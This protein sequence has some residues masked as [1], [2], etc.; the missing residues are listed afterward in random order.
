MH[1]DL[2]VINEAGDSEADFDAFSAVDLQTVPAHGSGRLNLPPPQPKRQR[3]AP[4]GAQG[5]SGP[6]AAGGSQARPELART[7]SS[8]HLSQTL[9]LP[10][11]PQ[12]SAPRR[13]PSERFAE[14]SLQ[15]LNPYEQYS[16]EKEGPPT[17]DMAALKYVAN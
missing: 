8:V 6:R 1:L 4:A 13:L 16:L 11:L 17:L 15:A 14:S 10:S 7:L 12:A 3:R 5:S 9:A 2:Q